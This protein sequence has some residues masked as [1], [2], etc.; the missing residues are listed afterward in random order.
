VRLGRLLHQLA[1]DE[2]EV[3][4]LL[5]L[6]LLTA[7]RRR[8][9]TAPDGEPVLLAEQDRTLWDARLIAE[10]LALV[11]RCL[12]VN[13]PGPY[14]LQAAIGAVHSEAASAVETDWRQIVALYDQLMVVAPTPV[15]GLNRAVAVG[16]V[17]GAERA[18]ALVEAIDLRGYHLFHAIRGEL[19]RRLGRTREAGAAYETAM[20]L[21]ANAAE[22]A[23]L[24]RKLAA[25]AEGRA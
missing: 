3:L 9:R 22:R 11:R 1:P 7:S 14:Q 19:L 23:L 18:L 15:A 10:G 20:A 25:C 17:D 5:A 24:A 4:G 21:T 6:M 8:A 12:E 2:P 16:E 13:R